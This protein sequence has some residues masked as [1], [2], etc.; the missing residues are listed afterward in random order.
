MCETWLAKMHLIVDT[1]RQEVFTLGINDLCVFLRE[2]R[3]NLRNPFI[4]DQYITF[5]DLTFVYYLRVY[6]EGIHSLQ[7]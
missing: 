7:R 3:A 1:A 2:M 4:R 5:E 6:N